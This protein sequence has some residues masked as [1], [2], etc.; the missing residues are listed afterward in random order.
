MQELSPGIAGAQAWALVPAN[1]SMTPAV[2]NKTTVYVPI[3]V[4]STRDNSPI[5]TPGDVVV[6]FGLWYR[7]AFCLFAFG[8]LV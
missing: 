6:R 8:L 4:V 3:S 1:C 2:P 7:S 5:R